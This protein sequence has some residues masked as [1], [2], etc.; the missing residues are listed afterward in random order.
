MAFDWLDAAASVFNGFMGASSQSDTNAANAQQAQNQMDFQERMSSTSHQREVKDLIAA[1]LNPILSATRGA[2]SPGG[3][4]AVMQSPY[5][6]GV[7]A[8]SGSSSAG[9]NRA[10]TAKA[11]AE[12]ERVEEETISAREAARAAKRLNDMEESDF[13]KVRQSGQLYMLRATQQFMTGHYGQ[14]IKHQ[15]EK[16][17]VYEW[18]K[19]LDNSIRSLEQSIRTG[20]AHEASLRAGAAFDVAKTALAKLQVNEARSS[21]DFYGD[22]GKS[23]HYLREGEKAVSTAAEIARARS[24]MSLGNRAA[25]LNDRKFK[26]MREGK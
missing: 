26:W 9:L 4:M 12:T 22:V 6:A 1:G 13:S 8:M 25:D 20:R 15:E 24:S 14:G 17:L 11:E 23:V 19:R 16:N 18:Q 7:N 5:Q 3:A 10:H 21:S 2:S